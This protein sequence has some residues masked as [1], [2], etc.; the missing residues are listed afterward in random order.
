MPNTEELAKVWI[1]AWCRDPERLPY[2]LG[3]PVMRVSEFG[4][5]KVLNILATGNPPI[6][7]GATWED[8]K[9]KLLAM[10]AS[11]LKATVDCIFLIEGV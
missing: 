8:A 6:A 7:I 11:S 10:G 3:H 4:V 9:A 5:H 2:G 1:R